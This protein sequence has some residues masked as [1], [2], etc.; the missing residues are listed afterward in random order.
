MPFFVEHAS[1]EDRQ[2]EGFPK[3]ATRCAS[4]DISEPEPLS[5]TGDVSDHRED[6]ITFGRGC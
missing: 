3:K 6:G 2:K 4:P 5:E 1:K